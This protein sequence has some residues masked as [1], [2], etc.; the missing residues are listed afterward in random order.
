[1]GC[2]PILLAV[3]LVIAPAVILASGLLVLIVSG[4]A[5]WSR[6]SLVAVCRHVVV[7][8]RED[9]GSHVVGLQS[10]IFF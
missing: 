7:D 8:V 2:F 1:M 6:A 5:D 4:R 3:L 9:L 10:D